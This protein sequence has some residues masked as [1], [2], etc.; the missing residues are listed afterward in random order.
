MD[1]PCSIDFDHHGPEFARDPSGYL[2]RARAVCPITRAHAYGGFWLVTGYDEAFAVLQDDAT[3]S[4]ADG[5]SIPPLKKKGP[6]ID[7]DPP[8]HLHYRKALGPHT[9]RFAIGAL[10]PEVR[11][12]TKEAVDAVIERGEADLIADLAAPVPAK[13]IMT[14]LGLDLANWP[15]YA[16]VWHDMFAR[17]QDPAVYEGLALVRAELLETYR[18]KAACPA[19]D[20]LSGVSRSALFGVLAEA[21]GAGFAAD[22]EG[23]EIAMTLLGAG[24]DTTTNMLG[25][26]AVWLSRNPE[27]RQRLIDEPD[28]MPRAVE[29]FFRF[30]ATA[31]A[32]ARTVTRDLDFFGHEFRAGDRVLVSF[33]AAN[34]DPRA[35]DRA[36][37]VVLDRW[38]NRHMAFG[39]GRHRCIGSHLARVVFPIM[40]RGLLDHMPDF[41]VDL[42][43]AEIYPDRSAVTGWKHVPCTFTPRPRA[44]RP[45]GVAS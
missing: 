30:F 17:P 12:W 23:S 42:D 25:E 19:S 24:V 43:R 34:H 40:L 27:Q 29:E 28:L 7:V 15:R 20:L 3:F 39:V 21:R 1:H 32:L 37:E 44:A 4:S 33:L 41:T 11:R 26:T 16:A 22:V 13:A 9:S 38:P 14:V 36:G 10:E 35:F 31:P 6:P 2:G 5:V 18:E 45:A 8:L